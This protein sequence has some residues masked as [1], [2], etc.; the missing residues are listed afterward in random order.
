MTI[1]NRI[2]RGGITLALCVVAAFVIAGLGVQ[3]IRFGGPIHQRNQLLS[4]LTGDILPPPEYVIEAYLEATQLDDHPETLALHQPR[5]ADLEKQYLAR[6]S[7]WR[8]S[9]LDP[10]IKQSMLTGS[11]PL[12]HEFWKTV[13]DAFLPAIARGDKAAA[14]A[15]FTRLT[16]SYTRH[17]QAID[18][19]VNATTAQQA[20]V[21]QT[22]GTTLIMIALVLAAMG[23]AILA[24][25][26]LCLRYLNRQVMEQIGRITAQLEQMTAGDFALGLDE[27]SGQDEIASLRRAALAFRD[28][29]RRRITADAQQAQV[30][31]ALGQGLDA[32]AAGDLT[33]RVVKPFAA[34]YEPLRMTFNQTVERLSVLIGGMLMSAEGVSSGADEIRAASD[35]LAQ[36]NLQQAADVEEWSAALTRVDGLVNQSATNARQVQQSISDTHHEAAEGAD[37]VTR[38]VD[39]MA[40]I[41]SSAQEISQIIGVI[42]G[43]AFQTNLLALN[44]GVEAARAGD[45]GRGFAVVASEVRALAQRSAEA[46]N[47]IKTLITSSGRQVTTGVALVAETGNLLAKIVGEVADVNISIADIADSAEDQAASLKR[48]SSAVVGMDRVTQHNAAMVEQATAAARSLVAEATTL[49]NAAQQFRIGGRGQAIIDAAA[50]DVFQP[51]RRRA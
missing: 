46:A 45:A 16:A 51:L 13:D 3:Q 5:L 11:V 6:E 44:A 2:Q 24:F 38:T 41:Q 19:L 9:A 39:A 27:A 4:D 32:I 33:H 29:G 7:F 26:V 14:D 48:V 30:V 17:R 49:R 31:S 22:S 47:D 20:K 37:V 23:A 40:G 15:A 35:D 36:R 18:T 42:D 1:R 43:I 28:A 8:D 34:D 21:A 50:A 12:A 10:E 25:I